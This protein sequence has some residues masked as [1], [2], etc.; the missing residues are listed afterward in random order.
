[1]FIKNLLEIFDKGNNIMCRYRYSKSVFEELVGLFQVVTKENKWYFLIIV[2]SQANT[3]LTWSLLIILALFP[4]QRPANIM[5][6][7]CRDTLCVW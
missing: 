6:E 2:R 4:S 3:N 1:M 7:F 5:I